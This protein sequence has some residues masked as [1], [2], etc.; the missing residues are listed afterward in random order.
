MLK[1]YR[2]AGN[3]IALK[4]V[5]FDDS[6]Y[7]PF[8][9]KLFNSGTA[10]L[11]AAILACIKLSDRSADDAEIILPAYA[12][13]DLVSAIHYAGAKSIL[14]ELEKDSTYLSLSQFASSITKNTIAV[15]AVNFLGI[16]DQVSKIRQIC[17][18]RNLF[19]ILDSA[20]WFPFTEKV[21][22]WSGDFN[23]ISFGRGKPVNLL[24]GGAVITSNPGYYSALPDTSPE[25][26]SLISKARHLLKIMIYILA[27][28]P[29]FYGIFARIPGL[30]IGATIFKPLK[31]ISGMSSLYARLIKSNIAK[32][33]NQKVICWYIHE[34]LIQIS[35]QRMIDLFPVN[36]YKGKTFLLRYPILIK[37]KSIRDKFFQLTKNYGV[38]ILYQ[39]PLNEISGMEKIIDQKPHYPCAS[40]FSDHLVTLPTHEDVDEKLIDHLIV[41]LKSVL[42]Q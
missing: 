17:D 36:V 15:I 5:P 14:V 13:P 31:S 19:L 25:V 7:R 35:D 1:V 12:C 6:E 26:I 22:E 39:R 40:T 24:H 34:K 41:T 32:T 38:S 28:Q 33:R 29:Y 3:S 27:I 8:R 16:P 30:N 11:S 4:S 20:Q 10:S 42:A 21:N 2:P 18:K 23:I 37:N 9:F